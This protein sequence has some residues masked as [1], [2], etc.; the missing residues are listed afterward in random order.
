M[1]VVMG[2]RVTKEEQ[3]KTSFSAALAPKILW[4]LPPVDRRSLCLPE[5]KLREKCAG[6]LISGTFLLTAGTGCFL[7]GVTEVLFVTKGML[8][9]STCGTQSSGEEVAAEQISSVCVG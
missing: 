2:H 4:Q 7:G 3:N 5:N 6:C 1:Q 9:S 8:L